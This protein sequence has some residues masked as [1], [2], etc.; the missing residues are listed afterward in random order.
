MRIC[1][2]PSPMIPSS[3]AKFAETLPLS[4]G[5]AFSQPVT[6][7][8]TSATTLP[9]TLAAPNFLTAE[10][11]DPMVRMYIRVISMAMKRL[12][13]ELPTDQYDFLRK[14]ATAMGTT[15]AGLIRKLIDERRHRLFR[16]A[17]HQE[18]DPLY[19][20]QGSFDGP[21]DLAESHDRYLYSPDTKDSK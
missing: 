2:N 15:V 8:S 3:S 20:R 4:C 18:A 9:L 1:A 21:A 6:V 13:L 10:T 14:E 17:L 7:F 19:T 16:E 11:V 5:P 12:T